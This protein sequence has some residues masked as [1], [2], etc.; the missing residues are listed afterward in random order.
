MRGGNARLTAGQ[1]GPWKFEQATRRLALYG[2]GD[3]WRYEIDLERC[4]TAVE[5]LDW[6]AQVAG[7]SWA[8]PDMLGWL[9]LALN[10]LL[11]LQGNYCGCGIER[12]P[13]PATVVAVGERARA[14]FDLAHESEWR[15]PD[16]LTHVGTYVALEPERLRHIKTAIEQAG[17]QELGRDES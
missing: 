9:L 17:V 5:I 14:E 8:T 13:R 7:K 1:W 6:L 12:G 3:R 11:S 10:E 15:D 2:E 16:G 4:K